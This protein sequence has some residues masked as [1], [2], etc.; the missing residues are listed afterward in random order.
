MTYCA[1]SDENRAKAT[2]NKYTKFREVWNMVLRYAS[3]D[4]QTYRHADCNRST[5]HP[6]RGWGGG[7]LNNEIGIRGK[8]HRLRLG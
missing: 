3:T 5:S 2:V 6:Y 8:W 4:I 1:E 7:G